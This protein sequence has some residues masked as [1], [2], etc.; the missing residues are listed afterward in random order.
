MAELIKKELLTK[1]MPVNGPVADFL[2]WLLRVKKMNKMYSEIAGPEGIE[3]I[4]EGLDF[5]NI[6]LDVKPRDL[7]KIPAEG[8]FITICNHPFGFLDG[9]TI[10][11]LVGE[12]RPDYKL[13]ANFLLES[14]EPIKMYF[15]SV[16]PFDGELY[17]PMGG[18]QASLKHLTEGKPLGLFP[19]GEV[20]TYYNGQKKITDR[21]WGKSSMRLIQR[22][23]VPVLPIYFHGH[24]SKLFHFMGKIHPMLRTALL[25]SEFL[26]KENTTIPIRIGDLIYPGAYKEYEDVEDLRDF[27]RKAVFDLEKAV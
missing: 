15:I 3:L 20:S 16:N 5:L 25:P 13:T 8:P 21:T 11:K 23:Q 19:A 7:D 6:K 26:K 1:L 4:N 2:L 9:I 17:K 12:R 22:A 27:M 14:I 18:T 10:I 24:N